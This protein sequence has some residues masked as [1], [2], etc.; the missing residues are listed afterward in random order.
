MAKGVQQPKHTEDEKRA[1]VE[2]ICALYE[3]Q[4]STIESCCA[5][6][7]ITYR[8]FAYWY[9]ADSELSEIYKKAKSKTDDVF[10]D[11]LRP[12][13]KR[14]IE[15]LIEGETKTETKTESG[16]GPMGPSSKTTITQSE[17]L[18]NSTVTIFAMKA[19]YPDKFVE[20]SELT[21]K[22]GKDLFPQ[23]AFNPSSI[24]VR[25]I[26]NKNDETEK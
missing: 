22:D 17:I 2:K 15:R 23:D 21:G 9:T 3:S 24:T 13:A 8:T 25:V 18:P 16:D 19:L 1:L 6:V 7:G 14:A 26:S 4:D 12:K 5:A 11:R 10:W 20:R